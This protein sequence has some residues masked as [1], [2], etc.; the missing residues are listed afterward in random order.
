[1]GEVELAMHFRALATDIRNFE[2]ASLAEGAAFLLEIRAA[3]KK[4]PPPADLGIRN[5]PG[6]KVSPAHAPRDQPQEHRCDALTI[7]R[8][9]EIG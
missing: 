4:R 8:G 1:M 9:C 5:W 6:K 3:T 7:F 2:G